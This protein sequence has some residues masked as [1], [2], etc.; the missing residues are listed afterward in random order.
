MTIDYRFHSWVTPG[1]N[2]GGYSSRLENLG[3][4]QHKKLPRIR[5]NLDRI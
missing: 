4:W 5:L 2:P 1:Q 3:H